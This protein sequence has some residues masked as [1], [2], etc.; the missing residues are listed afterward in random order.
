LTITAGA[1]FIQA[2]L[3]DVLGVVDHVGD[4]RPA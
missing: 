2:G 3:A 1:W 4:V